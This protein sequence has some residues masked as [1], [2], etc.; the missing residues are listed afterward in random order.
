MLEIQSQKKCCACTCAFELISM[1][2]ERKTIRYSYNEVHPPVRLKPWIKN[3]S[4]LVCER[5]I[6]TEN[7]NWHFCHDFELDRYTFQTNGDYVRVMRAWCTHTYKTKTPQK[8]YR[9]AHLNRKL[10]YKIVNIFFLHSLPF[11][12]NLK[13]NWFV[14]AQI[15]HTG[16]EREMN[17]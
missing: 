5:K 2:N 9:N 7:D 15:Q 14:D 4:F 12:A 10:W 16:T 11:I 17:E 13:C 3:V 1:P 8:M 6:E